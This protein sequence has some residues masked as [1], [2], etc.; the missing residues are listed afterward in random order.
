MM[1]SFF[2]SAV[3]SDLVA[4]AFSVSNIPD[5]PQPPLVAKASGKKGSCKQV[6]NWFGFIHGMMGGMKG[7]LSLF[8]S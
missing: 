6:S 1:F 3:Q 4:V 7:L 5:K 8:A 2:C